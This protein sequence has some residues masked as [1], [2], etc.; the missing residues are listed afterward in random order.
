[1]NKITTQARTWLGTRFHHQGRIKKS[2]THNGGVDCLG[3]LIGVSEELSLKS[4]D[5]II[6]LHTL[7]NI[8]YGDFPD[9]KFLCHQ[10]KT[11]LTEIPKNTVKSGDVVLM[12]FDNSP[13]HLGIISDY[14]LSEYNKLGLIHSY[15][16]AKKVIEHRLD[17]N[18]LAKI[19]N[20]F[21][22]STNK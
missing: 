13:Q 4:R 20:A 12:N 7:D 22:I 5:G 18:W 6:P 1:M 14:P 2:A 19:E 16:P 15:A 3:L 17:E 10:L 8:N 9:N 21:R 11:H